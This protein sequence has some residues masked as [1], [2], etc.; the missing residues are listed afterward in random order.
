MLV[1]DI[2]ISSLPSVYFHIQYIL[3]SRHEYLNIVYTV[4][5]FGGLNVN[6]VNE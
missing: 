3:C 5:P 6:N 1:E 2:K 4:R